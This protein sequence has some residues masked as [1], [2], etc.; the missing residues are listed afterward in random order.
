MSTFFLGGGGIKFAFI[1][2]LLR[3]VSYVSMYEEEHNKTKRKRRH[4]L[5][6][7]WQNEHNNYN[8]YHF[9]TRS[10][11]PSP[12]PLLQEALLLLPNPGSPT[13]SLTSSFEVNLPRR[14]ASLKEDRGRGIIAWRQISGCK[15]KMFKPRDPWACCWWR[16][17]L[18]RLSFVGYTTT[19]FPPPP[20]YNLLVESSCFHFRIDP[21]SYGEFK[22]VSLHL[23]KEILLWRVV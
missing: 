11:H 13:A 4:I 5:F 8:L 7:K 22:Q 6:K 19:P 10:V 2:K 21:T 18:T 14:R 20:V 17:W 12:H 23:P 9:S 16:W 15:G 1:T 3:L